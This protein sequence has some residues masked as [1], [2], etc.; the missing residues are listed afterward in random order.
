MKLRKELLRKVLCLSVCVCVYNNCNDWLTDITAH[1]RNSASSQR[2]SITMKNRHK[3]LVRMMDLEG[4]SPNVPAAVPSQPCRHHSPSSV[5]PHAASPAH[6]TPVINPPAAPVYPSHFLTVPSRGKSRVTVREIEDD[7]DD[8][9]LNMA[10]STRRGR[11]MTPPSSD[12]RVGWSPP[13][14]STV[15]YVDSNRGATIRQTTL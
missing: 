2:S 1:E 15:G 3:E 9:F 10:S 11:W 14:N 4:C 5:L 8:L 12:V 7:E 13:P 6:H